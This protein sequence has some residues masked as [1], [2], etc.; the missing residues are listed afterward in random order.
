MLPEDF[1]EWAYFGRVRVIKRMLRGEIDPSKFIIDMTRHTPVLCT[2][3]VLEDGSVFVNAK[4]VGAGFVPKYNLLK[5]VIVKLRAH[6]DHLSDISIEEYRKEGLK[7]LLNT[8]YFEEKE[9]AYETIDF[10]RIAMLEIASRIP[11]SSKHTWRNLQKNKRAC[12]LY[13]MPPTISFELHGTIEVHT[14]GPYHEYVN[15]VHDIYHYPKSGRSSYPCLIMKVEE[16]YDNSP[17][18]KGFG[19]R[20]L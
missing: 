18:P 4:V 12:L 5:E 1:I 13:Y 10:K 14:N 20:L 6:V 16:V 17:G 9:R 11:W 2:A 19:M 8:V 3:R 7:L 15:L